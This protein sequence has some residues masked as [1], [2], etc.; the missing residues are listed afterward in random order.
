MDQ[1]LGANTNHEEAGGASAF[2][3]SLEDLILE[4]VEGFVGSFRLTLAEPA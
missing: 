4:Q 1:W 2:E 3:H